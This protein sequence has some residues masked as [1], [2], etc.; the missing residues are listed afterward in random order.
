[1]TGTCV[2]ALDVGGTRIKAG[3][4]DAGHRILVDRVYDTDREDGPEAVAERVLDVLD[5]LAGEARGK[6]LT[7]VA[8]G[9]VLPGIVDE[10]AGRVVFS[11]NVGWRDLP[12]AE[13]LAGRT[14]LPAAV[15]HDVRA[16]GLAESVLGAGR[17]EPDLLFLPIGT[18]I[19]GAM[20]MDGRPYGGGG[21]AGEIGHTRVDPDGPPCPCGGAGC[22]ELYAAASSIGRRYGEL[23]AGG[24]RVSA[25]QVA[26]RVAAG[27]PQA[28]RIWQDAVDALAT[29]LHTYVTI[30]APRLIV[31]GGGLSESGELLLAPLREALTARLTFQRAPRIVRAALGDRA[32]LLGAA[33]LA[34][35]VT[36]DRD[37]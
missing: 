17:D 22:L 3:L 34:W 5:E 21:Y 23:H 15:G 37:R 29:A 11:A 20:I 1:M 8:A 2:V 14:G 10:A 9:V 28:A 31:V 32:G 27:E 4:V 36:G 35:R 16:G 19:A 25:A 26:E 7:P 33:L 13:R 30:C 18:G 6:D 12:L 24:E